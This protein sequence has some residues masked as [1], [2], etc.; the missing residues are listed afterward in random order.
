MIMWSGNDHRVQAK[1][2]RETKGMWQVRA[3]YIT[4]GKDAKVSYEHEGLILKPAINIA[5]EGL[6]EEMSWLPSAETGAEITIH[7]NKV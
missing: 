2:K 6:I 5:L 1:A 4:A 7:V 3:E